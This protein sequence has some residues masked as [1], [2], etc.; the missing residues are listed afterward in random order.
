MSLGAMLTACAGRHA[1]R[2][3]VVC[4]AERLSF[5]ALEARANRIA[6]GLIALGQPVGARVALYMPNCMALVE[7]MAACAKS[8]AVMVPVSTRLAPEEVRYQLDDTAPFAVI[9]TPETRDGARRAAAGLKNVR[10]IVAGAAEDGETGLDDVAAAGS[11]TPPVLPAGNLDICISYTSGTTGRPKGAVAT[12]HNRIRCVGEIGTRA[13]RLTEDDRILVATP[14]AHRT[15]IARLVTCFCLGSTLIVLPRFDAA[16]VVRL[17]EA[18]RATVIGVVP[19]IVRLLL[20]E[21]EKR[22]EACHSLRTMLATGE[23]FPPELKSRLF[24][25]LPKLGLY[26]FYS[27]TE[28]GLVSCLGPEE[29]ASHPDSIG[30]PVP[31]VEV[32]F[33]DDALVDVAAGAPGEVLV[34]SGEPGEAT[35]MR[36][37]FNRPAD[38]RA[39]FAGG[40]LRTGDIARIDADGY[41]YFID[42]ARDMIVSGGL[43]IYAAEVEAALARHPAVREAAVI[44]VP[45]E[46]F[47]E[48]VLAWVALTPDRQVSAD[49]LIDHCRSLIAGYKKPKQVRFI[50]KLPR[51]SVG[52]IVKAELRRAVETEQQMQTVKG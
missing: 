48:A 41:M 22:P 4:G 27:Q 17:I 30:R 38:T 33:V 44:G 25:A 26:S 9:F 2:K 11:E 23:V 14:M 6:G 18:E 52:K 36:E 51:N 35:V 43:N 3:A 15:G 12:H 1:E 13:W 7:A 45:D 31:G 34:R 21:I 28:A 40:W 49:Q 5:G 32:R 47:G 29:Q 10:L 8:G 50:D 20:P 24:A 19:T 46:R 37:Y 16:E 42:R 39:A